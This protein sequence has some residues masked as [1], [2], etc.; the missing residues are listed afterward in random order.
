MYRHTTQ[1]GQ[2]YLNG[3]IL[4]LKKAPRCSSSRCG[5]QTTNMEE[6]STGNQPIK[7]VLILSSFNINHLAPRPH[8]T[9]PSWFQKRAVFFTPEMCDCLCIIGPPRWDDLYNS[10]VAPFLV[11]SSFTSPPLFIVFR[12]I[13]SLKASKIT[14]ASHYL[15]CSLAWDQQLKN[16]KSSSFRNWYVPLSPLTYS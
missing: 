14:R 10:G 7:F 12:P 16:L 11:C 15:S 3:Q 9:D 4:S 5:C 8:S 1:Y 6:K 13:Q 2:S